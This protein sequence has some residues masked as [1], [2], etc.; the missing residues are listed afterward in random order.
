MIGLKAHA[1]VY[2]GLVRS[3]GLLLTGL[4]LPTMAP[5]SRRS[6]PCCASVVAGQYLSSS[7]S[8]LPALYV[9]DTIIELQVETKQRTCRG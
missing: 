5:V 4:T 9:K 2:A 3:A 8:L 6:T 1:C 7:S